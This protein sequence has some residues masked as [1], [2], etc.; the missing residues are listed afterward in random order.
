MTHCG[1]LL[2]ALASVRRWPGLLGL[3]LLLVLLASPWVAG[4]QA[5]AQAPDIQRQVQQIL[6]IVQL[7]QMLQQVQ[8]PGRGLPP[9]ERPD[10]P[11]LAEPL[12]L[13]T[14]PVAKQ[15]IE[16]ARDYVKAK[17]WPQ[18]ARLLQGLLD[19]RQDS[20]V[21]W[22]TEPGKPPPAWTS[23]R[24][25]AERILAALPP[26][27]RDGY[28]VLYDESAQTMLRQALDRSDIRGLSE[29]VRR[30][31]FTR[32]GATALGLLGGWYLDRGQ[33]DYAAACYERLLSDI[34]P[35]DL[36]TATL[37]RAYIA[38]Q[39]SGRTVAAD[40]VIE[41][42]APRAGTQGLKLGSR[43][44]A[45]AN[46]PREVPRLTGLAAPGDL[47]VYR[48][49]PQRVVVAAPS[50]P[51]LEPLFRVDTAGP[52]ARAR[53]DQAL[54]APDAAL[55]M[56]G[57]FPIVSGGRLV[58]RSHAGIHALDPRTGQELWKAPLE[59]S[60]E[61]LLGE[62]NRRQQ[63][64]R[65]F[66]LYQ[67]MQGLLYENTLCGTISSDGRLVFAI[68]DLP[69]PVHPQQLLEIEGGRK[70]LFSNLK[71]A[72]HYNQL[73]AIDA[74]TGQI[75][76]RAGG[77]VGKTWSELADG[78]F[79]GAPLAVGGQVWAVVGKQQDLTLV[80]LDAE[81]GE[82][83]WSQPLGIASGK[84][85]LDL[86]RRTQA[87]HLAYADGLLLCPCNAGAIVAV[88]PMSRSL[89]WAHTYQE[90]SSLTPNID[91]PGVLPAENWQNGWRGCA[92]LVSGSRVVFTAPDSE[93]I[94]CLR[95]ADGGL[96]WKTART[97]DDLFVA[98]V[99]EG[100]VLVVGRN[101]CRAHRLE[102]GALAWQ[103]ATSMP[104]GQGAAC[105]S[106][107]YLPLKEGAVLALNVRNP[108]LSAQIACKPGNGDGL[109]GNLLCHAGRFWSQGV[110]SLTAYPD[111]TARLAALDATL[112]RTTDNAEARAERGRLRL[113]QGQV[114]ESI[115]DLEKALDLLAGQPPDSTRALRERTE[116][117]LFR[118][119]T[120][121]IEGNF[122]AAEGRLERYRA[123]CRVSVDG[124]A[125]GADLAE[126]T[127]REA[128]QRRREVQYHTVVARGY[129]QIGRLA[130]AVVAYRLLEKNLPAAERLPHPEDP[131]VRIRRDL[132]LDEQLARVVRKAT[133]EQRPLLERPLAQE[134]EALRDRSDR[135]ELERFVRRTGGTGAI[136]EEARKRLVEMLA[137]ESSPREATSAA[138]RLLALSDDARTP[139]AGKAVLHARARLL[140]RHGRLADATE[141]Y[142]QLGP[143]LLD[144][145]RGDPR[146]LPYLEP[147]AGWQGR[148]MQIEEKPGKF[149]ERQLAVPP[150][151]PQSL[152]PSDLRG[153]PGA[154]GPADLIVASRVPVAPAWR[155][156]MVYADPATFRLDITNCGPGE[157]DWS[158]TLPFL[159][160]DRPAMQIGAVSA[161]LLDN[162]LLVQAGAL[163]AGIDLLERRLRWTC[164]ILDSDTIPV[165]GMSLSLSG[166]L[167][168]MT[169][170]GRVLYRLGIVGPTS[171]G[172][173][174]V[175]TRSGLTALDPATGEVRWQRSDVSGTANVFGD[176]EHLFVVEYHLDASV[177]S[178]RAV[179]VRDGVAVAIPDARE[180]FAKK[181]AL[182][183]RCLLVSDTDAGAQQAAKERVRLSLYDVLQG[184][185]VWKKSWPAESVVL[186]TALSDVVAVLNPK[187]KGAVL[188]LATGKELIAFQIDP[189]H[190]KPDQT[191]VLLRDPE[192]WYVIFR[193]PEDGMGADAL[194]PA[195]GGSLE[196]EPINGML[197]AFDRKTGEL[198]WNKM[199]ATQALL[200]NRFDELPVILA[201]FL[202]VRGNP[203][204]ADNIFLSTRFLD[205]RTGKLI[206]NQDLSIADAGSRD[207]SQQMQPF[208][209]LNVT[210]HTGAIELVHPLRKLRLSPK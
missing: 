172:T 77:R 147:Y 161:Q 112:N 20:F 84:L 59:L 134:W 100:L 181:I 80:C 167:E 45:I 168:V 63:F 129:E 103:H 96:V 32:P 23:V 1:N 208:H 11:V 93:S 125:A 9:D 67:G 101:A 113:E 170:S 83:V 202:S 91:M 64:N 10:P 144:E 188:D 56:P 194:Q 149:R 18:A 141:T 43:V 19:G 24:S 35:K 75:A 54:K 58:Y 178:V 51:L 206:W 52:D 104:A 186:E 34:E 145:A 180:A 142:R 74:T 176:A 205:K 22:E 47:P 94:R 28:R 114:A 46:L 198:C 182:T 196:Y 107:Y 37:Y 151:P 197:Y 165:G 127:R 111:M 124:L 123:L 146:L 171:A 173:L 86:I 163:V 81:R 98:G 15:K 68:D 110:A 195:F 159:P 79:L 207:A 128:E 89:V 106:W 87:H 209:T 154:T 16:A 204:T 169:G 133:P 187:G 143:D 99:Q 4:P 203:G 3:G 48:G 85:S 120:Q 69:L 88:D 199:M 153:G 50:A 44:V 139:E 97:E 38:F 185:T 8:Q 201:A 130:E 42:L 175:L 82:L 157:R 177:R 53:L 156:L 166:R 137:S 25:E 66:G 36:A 119:L 49:T 138:L 21:R 31:R 117:V 132:W 158:V 30:Y 62:A 90:R 60:L 184:K 70:H 160:Q 108:T 105:G 131:A 135:T 122:A 190:R 27:G 33:A 95:L 192:R 72:I 102:N 78:F 210:P 118:G 164:H 109:A 12:V 121:M 2:R 65:W 193:N 152:I 76:W 136:G 115:A 41:T 116:E 150:Q 174:C 148:T 140:V 40:R 71:D 6:Q 200:M 39:A 155:G 55:G 179:R 183:G 14:D 92:P 189:N 61:G 7:K 13:P 162:L 29:V 57:F 26:N 5:D 191:A 126:R 17:D 73:V